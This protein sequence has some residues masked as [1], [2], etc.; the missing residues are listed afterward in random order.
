MKKVCMISIVVV[1]VL[2]N[3]LAWAED[4]AIIDLKTLDDATLT[5]L[6]TNVQAEMNLRGLLSESTIFQ[7]T[8]LAG[9]DIATGSYTYTCVSFDQ[10]KQEQYI[11]YIFHNEE[12]FSKAKS[13]GNNFNSFTTNALTYFY[14]RN[15]GESTGINLEKGNILYITSP[16]IGII[17]EN[18]QA[19]L[20]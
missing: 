3:S 7:G 17:T 8:Y 13:D 19:W 11:I 16:S 2:C 15:P 20:P 12:A 10:N 4:S 6:L 14:V 18:K 5:T 9:R 1:L